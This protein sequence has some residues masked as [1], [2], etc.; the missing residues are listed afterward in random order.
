M[1]YIDICLLGAALSMDAFAVSV[2][3]SLVYK[4]YNALM[5]ALFFGF[6]Q[7]IMPLLGFYAGNL[8]SDFIN[9]YS[10]I[11]S[12]VILGLIGIK[13]IIDSL[14]P[15]EETLIDDGD[16]LTYKVLFLQAVA[17]SID[18]FAVGVSF[19]GISFVGKALNIFSVCSLIAVITFLLSLL[20]LF[21]GKKVGNICGDKMGIVG[22]IILILIGLKNFL[23]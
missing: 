12:L 19:V 5:I 13:M 11:I 6:F 4:K 22:G 2:T 1:N 16:V 8:F 20:A 15:Q 14:H 10:G 3:N 7:G 23:F 17:T 18:A 21:I 9:R